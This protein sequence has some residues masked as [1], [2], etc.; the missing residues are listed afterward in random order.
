MVDR[1]RE[2]EAALG[3]GY[4]RVEDNE[5]ET[6]V[7]QRRCLR[8]KG[9]KR[10]GEALAPGDLEYLRPAPPESIEPYRLE[11]VIGRR[12]KFSKERGDAV[13]AKDLEGE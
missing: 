7:L 6:V 12:L 9:P 13:L 4:K 1:C 5:R 8:L 11:A 10:A 3:D 2:L